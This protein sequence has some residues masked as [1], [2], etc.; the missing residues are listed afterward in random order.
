MAST[1]TGF[2]K[3]LINRLMP[4]SS[5]QMEEFSSGCKLNMKVNSEIEMES[6]STFNLE[7]G[8][9]MNLRSGAI[10]NIAGK[11]QVTSGGELE[12][13]SGSTLNVESGSYFNVDS[14]G[15]LRQKNITVCIANTS[16]P[17]R[18]SL[19][20]KSTKPVIVSKPKLGDSLSVCF[21]SSTTSKKTTVKFSSLVYI[22]STTLK[23]HVVNVTPAT[24]KSR[25]IGL[26]MDFHAYSSKLIY[27]GFFAS[28]AQYTIAFAS[29]T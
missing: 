12:L 4:S 13:E 24:T 3:S 23:K 20:L 26:R 25:Q 28:T 21:L 9:Y 2:N 6:G 29:A 7:S 18:G 14:G 27:G 10:S 11:T 16:S 17:F 22:G 19:V 8:S 1:S 5:G 15:Y